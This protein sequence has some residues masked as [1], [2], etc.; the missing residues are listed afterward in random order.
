MLS[1]RTVL[2]SPLYLLFPLATPPPLPPHRLS[3]G[4]EGYRRS[5]VLASTRCFLHGPSPR[6]WS[7]PPPRPGPTALHHHSVSGATTVGL[8]APAPATTVGPACLPHLPLGPAMTGVS[9]TPNPNP[10][11]ESRIGGGSRMRARPAASSEEA[12]GVGGG[13]RLLL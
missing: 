6:T 1:D 13:R 8:A 3:R 5:P 2:L 11:P 7:S 12:G 4:A 10:K 9:P